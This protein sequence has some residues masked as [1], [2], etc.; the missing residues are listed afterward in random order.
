M[1]KI[2]Y[3]CLNEFF[4]KS[5]FKKKSFRDSVAIYPINISK[6]SALTGDTYSLFLAPE[7][8]ATCF[9]KI[10]LFV[11]IADGLRLSL[12]FQNLLQHLKPSPV[13]SS[14]PLG[15]Q[16]RF[17]HSL[18]SIPWHLTVGA[19]ALSEMGGEQWATV[20]KIG[21]Q[22]QV[23]GQPFY[24][25][26]FNTYWLM[27]FAAD[28]STRGK[29]SEVFRQ[30]AAAGLNVCRTWAFNDAG[31][32][33]LQISPSVYDEEVFKGLDFV[34]SEARRNDIR[35]ILSMCNN[36]EDYGGKSQYVRWGN[37][38][39]LNLTSDDEFFLDPTIKGYYKAHVQRVLSRINTFTGMIYKDDPTIFAWELINEPRC[40]LDPSGDTLQADW[41]KLNFD[42]VIKRN[43]RWAGVRW[44]VRNHYGN[45]LADDGILCRS[46]PE[47]D[48]TQCGN[49]HREGIQKS[50]VSMAP[51]NDGTDSTNTP[52]KPCPAARPPETA[53][54]RSTC[55]HPGYTLSLPRTLR[56][57]SRGSGSIVSSSVIPASGLPSDDT[58]QK[59]KMRVVRDHTSS[60]TTCA[61]NRLLNNS[62]RLLGVLL[63][64]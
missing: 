24:V 28:H 35:L 19:F 5:F 23:T 42:D 60:P 32:R 10:L 29:V 59:E 4:Q 33:A 64:Y 49:T 53:T 7:T 39:G 15:V 62:L 17:F 27:V 3:D 45:I 55:G 12:A 30:A 25:N 40:P 56:L 11:D 38:A 16:R 31:W 54:T 43:Y 61:H 58:M 2:I 46:M 14:G 52:D 26:G 34:V 9:T 44:V 1:V 63:Y 22:F 20:E 50:A 8:A 36:W 57:G 51:S 37:E 41:L 47:E 48:N 6:P 18:L 13:I 21:T